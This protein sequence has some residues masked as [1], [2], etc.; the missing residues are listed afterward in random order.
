MGCQMRLNKRDYWQSIT[1]IIIVIITIMRIIIIRI[2]IIMIIIT[3]ANTKPTRKHQGDL[4]PS[5]SPS[6]G[7][8]GIPTTDGQTRAF[9]VLIYPAIRSQSEA[10]T[11]PT[12]SQLK[13]TRK[14][15]RD[16]SPSNS[17]SLH[18]NKGVSLDESRSSLQL[19]APCSRRSIRQNS[20]HSME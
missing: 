19:Y 10:N 16:P 11:K 7:A 14:H 4:S 8:R 15:Q 13:A 2:I 5:N 3:E 20:K 1:I 6:G 12:R 9:K 17:P 18:N